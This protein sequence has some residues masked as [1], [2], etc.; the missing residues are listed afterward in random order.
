MASNNSQC[1]VCEEELGSFEPP[2]EVE[3]V[4]QNDEF[5]TKERIEACFKPTYQMRRLKNNGAILILIWSFLLMWAYHYMKSM[6]SVGSY[7]KVYLYAIQVLIVLVLPFAGWL[8]DVCFGRYKVIYWSVRTMWICAL[9][10]TVSF[11]VT[12][13]VES[14]RNSQQYIQVALLA[15]LGTGFAGFQANII[16]FGVDQLIDASTTEIISFVH[17]YTWVVV[18]SRVVYLLTTCTCPQYNCKL[19]VP[20]LLCMSISI[21]LCLIFLC[22][23]LLIKEPVT[24]NPFK[25]IY[26]VMKYAIKNRRPRQ[27]SAFTYCEDEVPTRIDF[28]KRKYGGPFTT[29]QVEDVKTFF[30]V[31]GIVPITSTV[32]GMTD[33]TGFKL[34]I[35]RSFRKHV[36]EK[37]LDKCSYT[38]IYTDTL[39]I[40]GAFLIPLNEIL[41]YPVFY[42]CLPSI[43]SYWKVVLGISLH[44]GRY[45]VLV[46]LVTIAKQHYIQTN[47]CLLYTSPSPRDATLSR[48]PSSA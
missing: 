35:G 11:I 13:L 42:R 6:V 20:L 37:I 3:I 21:V 10:L 36:T 19:I 25:L 1:A 45:I 46:I 23:N 26:K 34:C 12:Q 33:E 44:L 15:F 28:G 48:M 8:A 16:Q 5:S 4:S 27:R 40:T 22:K 32:F 24:Q 41:I 47:G 31:I 39:Y 17:W 9:L 14:Y 18:S 29:E 43:K 30:R 38:F 2:T 7:P